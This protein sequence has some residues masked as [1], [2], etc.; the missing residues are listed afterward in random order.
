MI[1]ACSGRIVSDGA[2][3]RSSEGRRGQGHAA[4]TGLPIEWSETQNIVWKA[5]VA[6]TGWSSPVVAG[7][8]V[9]LTTATGTRDVSLRALAFDVATGR[10]ARRHEVFRLRASGPDQPKNSHAS[11]TPV[12]DGERIYVHFGAQG[13]AALTP[14][15]EMVWKTRFPYESQHGAGGSPDSL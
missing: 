7:G 14:I 5:P 3:G 10:Q 12:A 15:G 2:D 8:R 13:T 4:E 6:G 1:L 9:W 11:P